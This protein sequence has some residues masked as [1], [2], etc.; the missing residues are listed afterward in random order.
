[1]QL[2]WFISY[3]KRYQD[4]WDE[5]EVSDVHSLPE[6]EFNKSQFWLNVVALGFGVLFIVV[7]PLLF[8]PAARGSLINTFLGVHYGTAIKWHRCVLCCA[9]SPRAVRQ[10]CHAW[11]D[12]SAAA[13]AVELQH[14]R[15]SEV[16]NSTLSSRP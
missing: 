5:G 1:M 10:R 6:G 9:R 15:Q 11:R 3:V 8:L 14:L 13:G 7:G 12:V 4:E 2:V 16:R